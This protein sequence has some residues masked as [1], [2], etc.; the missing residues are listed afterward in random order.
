MWKKKKASQILENPPFEK[1]LNHCIEVMG[2][3]GT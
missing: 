3:I 1:T 2:L